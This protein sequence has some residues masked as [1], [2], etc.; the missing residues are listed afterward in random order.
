MKQLVQNKFCNNIFTFSMPE[1]GI[2]TSTRSSRKNS[3]GPTQRALMLA[4][5]D[6]FPN[7]D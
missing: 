6:L 3:Q 2:S 7:T 4:F 1:W 5:V